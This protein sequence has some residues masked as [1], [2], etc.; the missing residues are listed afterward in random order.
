MTITISLAKNQTPY[1]LY[2]VPF[3]Y[4]SDDRIQLNITTGA[5]ASVELDSLP[6]EV[7]A[8]LRNGVY[9]KEIT[10]SSYEA[11]EERI[12][13][14]LTPVPVISAPVI[15]SAEVVIAGT[16]DEQTSAPQGLEELS[17]LKKQAED[18]LSANQNTLAGL[19]P[20]MDSLELLGEMLCIE[21]LTRARKKVILA[22]E[23]RLNIPTGEILP[24]LE[25]TEVADAE[26]VI[27][28]VAGTI[29]SKPIEN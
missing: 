4:S 20:K 1:G 8:Q 3:F 5:H 22:L 23:T 13:L 25:V 14:L 7:L 18:K 9:E 29:S 10:V 2:E 6:I 21:K 28:S 15:A 11:I 12:K 26:L 27:D 16:I 24:E 17:E 19:I